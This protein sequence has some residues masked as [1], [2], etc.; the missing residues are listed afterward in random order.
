[1]SIDSQKADSIFAIGGGEPFSTNLLT[2]DP[3]EVSEVDINTLAGPSK[4]AVNTE[5]KVEKVEDVKKE[6]AQPKEEVKEEPAK[7]NKKPQAAFVIAESFKK[8]GTL[9][10]YIEIPEN[11]TAKELKALL[12]DTA[13]KESEEILRA[14][15]ESKYD[16]E[17]LQT[18]DLLSRGIDP[19]DIK[20]VSVYKKIA[21]LELPD[22][23]DEAIR[24]KQSAI[25]A[26][27]RDKGISDKKIK[28][29]VE[30]AI[31]EDEGDAEFEEAKK[32]FGGK[33]K[34]IESRLIKEAKEREDSY[35]KNQETIN[36][37]I[38]ALIKSG[39]IYN[40]EDD[41]S[42]KEL[43]DFLFAQTETYKDNEGKVFKVTPFQK[44]LSEYQKDTKKQL[45]FAK[46]LMSDFDLK[47][48]ESKGALAKAD[49]LDS[50]LESA[51]SEHGGK[52]K[53]NKVVS[54]FEQNGLTEIF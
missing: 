2:A 18:A 19:D 38:K 33:G 6:H 23:Y 47:S 27:Y 52:E 49:E 48:I 22:D 9:P 15:Y 3:E 12:I 43:E 8:D 13:K 39:E 4:K 30:D 20:E 24:L 28:T 17:V 1:M 42:K 29:L 46:L 44:K 25:E 35:V 11:I 32:Y 16:P 53:S 21:A 41:K 51:V 40:T 37:E 10:E 31:D 54:I 5:E 36:K 14:E 45:I 34:E 50:Y 7:D 26:M